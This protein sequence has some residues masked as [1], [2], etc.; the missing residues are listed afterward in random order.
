[1]KLVI[2]TILLFF[3]PGDPQDYPVPPKTS[4]QLFYIQRNHN[5]NTIMYDAHFLSDGNLDPNKP[6]DAYWLRYDEDSARKELSWIDKKY[7][8]GISTKKIEN[9]PNQYNV[10]LVADEERSF[11]LKKIAPHRAVLYT[12][13]NNI[14]SALDH[15]WIQA[16]NSGI[17]PEV[18]YVE[19]F[20][21]D[22]TTNQPIYEKLIVND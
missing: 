3:I 22:T 19:L 18:K 16:D 15:L 6:I 10:E 5:A 12:R 9:R 21:I 13:I 1:M 11:T 17:W 2:V 4:K 20:G 8:Y 7:A 14:P